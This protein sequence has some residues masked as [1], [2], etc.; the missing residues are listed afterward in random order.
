MSNNER[1][2][3]KGRMLSFKLIDK[4]I[5]PNNSYKVLNGD[6][7]IDSSYTKDQV[8]RLCG[9]E[10]LTLDLT[11]VSPNIKR[12]IKEVKGNLIDL[13]TTASYDALSTIGGYTNFYRLTSSEGLSAL[14]TIGGDAYFGGLTSSEGLSAL[15]TI[16]GDANFYRLTSSEGLSALSSIGGDA[17]FDSLTNAEGLSALS[18]IGGDANFHSL[19]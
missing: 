13:S 17:N 9:I 15:S 1:L 4:S 8:L 11:L 12:D 16:G 7:P 6:L 10:G 18:S 5:Y 14:S 19:D 3:L 2:K